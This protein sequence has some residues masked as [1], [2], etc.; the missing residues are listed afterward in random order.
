MTAEVFREAPQAPERSPPRLVVTN[1]VHGPRGFHVASAHVPLVQGSFDRE[2]IGVVAI[3]EPAL[4]L[5]VECDDLLRE[6]VTWPVQTWHIQTCVL[7]NENCPDRF[8][9]ICR[10]LVRSP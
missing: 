8:G 4:V 9:K 5:L 7:V 6:H 1:S 10:S 2:S 3:V